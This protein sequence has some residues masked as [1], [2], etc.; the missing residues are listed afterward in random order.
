MKTIFIILLAL[1]STVHAGE[2]A[3]SVFYYDGKTS[4]S[5]TSGDCATL[6]VDR[7]TGGPGFSMA[8]YLTGTIDVGLEGVLAPG[9][10][11]VLLDVRKRVGDFS[12]VLSG[13][14]LQTSASATF[15]T[16]NDGRNL[17]VRRFSP[18][19]GVGVAY[20]YFSVRAFQSTM[21]NT[22]TG[23]RVVGTATDGS[24]IF[25]GP[26]LSADTNLKMRSIW[27]GV[28]FPIEYP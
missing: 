1:S 17:T 28:Q 8:Y 11:G 21:S 26:E 24:P 20:K 22:F 9:G 25:G 4:A 10:G 13:G 14:T 7:T 3:T 27:I 6:V 12:V 19:I 23:R 16:L 5:C 15:G 2:Y 18:A